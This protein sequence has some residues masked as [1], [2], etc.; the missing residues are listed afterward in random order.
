M[1]IA[2]FIALM[3]AAAGAAAPESTAKS[4]AATYD[5]IVA[6]DET[7]PAEDLAKPAVFIKESGKAAIVGQS[8][9]GPLA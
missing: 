9:P 8:G 1:A 2:E 3:T 5:A 6:T 4:A 7:A